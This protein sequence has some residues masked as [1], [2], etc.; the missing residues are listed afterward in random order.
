MFLAYQ[1][2]TMLLLPDEEL[3]TNKDLGY[4]Y[5]VINSLKE[6]DEQLRAIL[7]YKKQAKIKSKSIIFIHLCVCF[8]KGMK[9]ISGG[10]IF[11]VKRC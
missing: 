8:R 10:Q 4:V 11:S 9:P 1:I 7:E 2:N 3:K 6:N 5:N